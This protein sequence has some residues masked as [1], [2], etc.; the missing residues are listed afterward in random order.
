MKIEQV[1]QP[2]YSLT[3][4]ADEVQALEDIFGN[5]G[6]GELKA[7]MGDANHSTFV[8]NFYRLLT[9]RN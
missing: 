8:N 5:M 4:M 6:S 2:M 1:Q 7:L 9:E 3:L